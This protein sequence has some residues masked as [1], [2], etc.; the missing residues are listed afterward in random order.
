M[1]TFFSAVLLTV[2]VAATQHR[3]DELPVLALPAGDAAW[4]V[5]VETTGGL[6]GR[7]TGSVTASSGGAVLCV[8]MTNCPGNLQLELR[9]SLSHLVSVISI[10]PAPQSSSS[11]AV[12][13]CSDC[14]TTT[15][16]VQRRDAAGDHTLRY[17]WD[18]ST[19][20]AVPVD[21]RRLHAAIMEL[22]GRQ[23]R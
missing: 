9:R 16:T 11:P 19:A 18:V 8:R 5:R 14:V 15:M 12:T 7:G 13:T 23:P 22:T 17:T 21:A 2:A 6:T 4:A 20:H 3:L 1:F 10:A